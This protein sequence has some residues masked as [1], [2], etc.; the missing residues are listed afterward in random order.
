[1]R[2]PGPVRAAALAAI[3]I[4][5]VGGTSA[6][7]SAQESIGA[8]QHFIGLV[9]GSH[10]LPTVDTVCP[11]PIRQGRRGAV[12]G[13]QTLS[14]AEVVHGRGF[15]GPLS[16]VYA[17]FPPRPGKTPTQFVFDTYGT[18]QTIPTS[19]RVPCGGKGR[20]VF[21]PCPYLAPCVAGWTPD[22]VRVQFANI[23]A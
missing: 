17:W 9:N 15:T 14:V 12:A 23:A 5:V 11:G 21:S 20:V 7:A 3:A 1:M 13:G 18:P 2:R 16:Q 8:N 22:V 6:A 4:A 10:A 19:V